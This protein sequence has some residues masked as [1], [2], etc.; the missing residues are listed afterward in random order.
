MSL[1]L[2]MHVTKSTLYNTAK[3]KRD[4]KPFPPKQSPSVQLQCKSA[5][6]LSLVF[7]CHTTYLGILKVGLM[8]LSHNNGAV[9]HPLS[10]E[11]LAASLS[12]CLIANKK[13]SSLPLASPTA[14]GNKLE[15]IVCGHNKLH[16][17]CWRH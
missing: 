6:Q 9:C 12:C 10:T 7:G 17:S 8:K 14:C 5:L 1:V 13:G 15:Q 16:S 11:I 2:K 3:P 4:F